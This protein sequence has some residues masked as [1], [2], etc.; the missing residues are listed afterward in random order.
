MHTVVC[1]LCAGGKG[2]ETWDACMWFNETDTAEKFKRGDINGT[3][4]GRGAVL[5]LY[6]WLMS[7]VLLHAQIGRACKLDV[8]S[9]LCALTHELRLRPSSGLPVLHA[10]S[11]HGA[12]LVQ[13]ALLESEMLAQAGTASGQAAVT[14]LPTVSLM[15]A[16]MPIDPW[17]VLR[18]STPGLYQACMVHWNKEGPVISE[19]SEHSGYCPCHVQMGLGSLPVAAT[20]RIHVHVCGVLPAPAQAT[21][22][23]CH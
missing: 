6:T 17:P 15:V 19:S 8:Q 13:V 20:K 22:I 18:Y 16:C 4:V 23:A 3:K 11:V 2:R 1:G 12:W 21:P 5:L 7:L 14:I 9:L 10:R